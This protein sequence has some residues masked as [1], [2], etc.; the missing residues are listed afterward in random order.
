MKI[1][2]NLVLNDQFVDL[3]HRVFFLRLETNDEDIS[4]TIY[5]VFNKL[6][7][8]S[9]LDKFTN[10]SIRKGFEKSANDTI[11]YLKG[12]L[13]RDN[14]KVTS[15]TGEYI[16]SVLSKDALVNNYGHESIPLAEL[17]GRKVSN[18]PSYD[19]YTID[20]NIFVLGE[21]KYKSDINAYGSSLNQIAE[22]ICKE[23]HI[24]DIP[25][26][27]HFSNEE[28]LNNLSN[29][30]FHICAAFST[31]DIKTD[32]LINNILTNKRFLELSQEKDVFLVA[33]NLYEK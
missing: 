12:K 29:H 14:D 23:K 17:L 8:L 32:V 6:L 22:F 21:A 15:D 20:N 24:S 19:F 33:V 10:E 31:T 27:F 18:N 4:N 5:T 11:N 9:W 28:T 1:V 25:L 2:D 13:F 30:I 3:K 26:L 7:D 16:V